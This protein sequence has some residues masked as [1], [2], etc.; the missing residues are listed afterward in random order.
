MDDV[1]EMDRVCTMC[2][3]TGNKEEEIPP[4][5]QG[6]AI[7]RRG[8]EGGGGGDGGG[9][10]GW[11]TAHVLTNVGFLP[12][13]TTPS[14]TKI[15]SSHDILKMSSTILFQYFAEKKNTHTHN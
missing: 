15:T 10:R 3:K 6:G 9:G 2:A 4:A 11:F 12:T 14:M 13:S 8:R 5:K 1:R 7:A